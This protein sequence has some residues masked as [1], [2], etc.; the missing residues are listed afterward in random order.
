MPKL[1]RRRWR[2]ASEEDE[3]FQLPAYADGDYDKED[4][5]FGHTNVQVCIFSAHI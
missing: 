4:E 5:L 2:R 1:K 3:D